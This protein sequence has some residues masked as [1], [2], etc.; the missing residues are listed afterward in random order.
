MMDC[1]ARSRVTLCHDF[2]PTALT[3]QIDARCSRATITS[4][5]GILVIVVLT[6]THGYNAVRGHR[7][8]Q[9]PITLERKITSGGK[10]I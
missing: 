6:L 9:P 8:G 2:V 5:I 10:Q 4:I 7:T 3:V 1:A